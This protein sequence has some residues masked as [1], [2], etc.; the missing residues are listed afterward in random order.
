MNNT[1]SNTSTPQKTKQLQVKWITFI[2]IASFSSEFDNCAVRSSCWGMLKSWQCSSGGFLPH[3]TRAFDYHY[4]TTKLF[5]PFSFLKRQEEN[6]KK[7]TPLHF[8]FITILPVHTAKLHLWE[9]LVVGW[10][11]CLCDG[12][13]PAQWIRDSTCL[14][15]LV[16]VK[17]SAD[18]ATQLLLVGHLQTGSWHR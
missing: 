9:S 13:F 16:H 14:L 12:T 10:S 2:C 4:K 11:C 8:L 6:F 1:K 17:A 5:H 7:L 3:W 18:S 15:A